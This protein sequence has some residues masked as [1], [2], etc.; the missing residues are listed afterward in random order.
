[1]TDID[2]NSGLVI[3]LALA[4]A[5]CSDEVPREVRAEAAAGAR[6]A[7]HLVVI[8]MTDDMRFQPAAAVIARGDTVVWVNDG[9]MPHTATDDPGTARLD[10][11]NVLPAGA[12]QWDSGPLEPGRRFRHVFTTSG[13][14]TYLCSFH[15]T[16]G[17]IGRLSVE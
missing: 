13:D 10:E 1:V 12:G 6:P 8:R 11:H 2:W 3:L 16:M 9:Q 7:D 4:V 15:E 17:M 5:G 14:Y